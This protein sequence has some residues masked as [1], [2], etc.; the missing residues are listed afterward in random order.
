V[1]NI[2][3]HTRHSNDEVKPCNGSVWIFQYLT[4]GSCCVTFGDFLELTSKDGLLPPSFALLAIH[5][6]K[7]VCT[8]H[9]LTESKKF[10]VKDDPSIG[11]RKAV[12]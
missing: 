12:A 2:K 11:K 7:R 9:Q 4:R 1:G 8:P 10:K 3:V 5:S 6:P